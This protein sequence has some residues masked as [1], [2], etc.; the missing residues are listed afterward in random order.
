MK[1]P[2]GIMPRKKTDATGEKSR[3][4]PSGPSGKTGFESSGSNN[5]GSISRNGGSRN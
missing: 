3:N 5:P 2:K 4:K 1:Q